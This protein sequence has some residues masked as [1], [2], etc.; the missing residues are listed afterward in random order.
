MWAG[1]RS[2]YGRTLPLAFGGGSLAG[3]MRCEMRPLG[4]P[5]CTRA[6]ALSDGRGLVRL[7]LNFLLPSELELKLNSEG[8]GAFYMN[9]N[10]RKAP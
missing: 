4:W 7:L 1:W 8:T 2:D 3:L 6:S 10:C 9:Q 5:V